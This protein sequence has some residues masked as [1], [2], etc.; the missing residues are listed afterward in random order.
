MTVDAATLPDSVDKLKTIIV[1]VAQRAQEYETENKLLKEEISLL[2]HRLFG[3]KSEKLP[4]GSGQLFLFNEAEAGKTEDEDTA[5]SQETI[6]VPAHE[7]RRGHRKPLPENLPRVEVVHDLTDEQKQ[8]ACG[9]QKSCIGREVSEQ[10]DI[11]PPKIQVIQHI[12]PKYVC[13]KC[14]GVEADEP[15]VSIAP[16]PEQLIPKA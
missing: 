11:T 4:A 9:Q 6:A 12:R 14:E 1:D 3:R 15:A 8:C 5:P 10:L 2:K 16:M 7:R 13:R